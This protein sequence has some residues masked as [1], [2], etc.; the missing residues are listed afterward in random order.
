MNCEVVICF[1][2]GRYVLDFITGFEHARARGESQ[3]GIR[4]SDS[5]KLKNN[6]KLNKIVKHNILI[7]KMVERSDIYVKVTKNMET[8]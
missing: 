2:E 3:R 1:R 4:N 8:S 6:F 5:C 7:F